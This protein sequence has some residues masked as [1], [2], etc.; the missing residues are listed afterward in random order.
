MNKIRSA[1]KIL[2][3]EWL[4]FARF[5][6]EI[7]TFILL[8]FVYIIVLGIIAIVVRLFRIVKSEK[9]SDS[10]VSYWKPKIDSGIDRHKFQ[11]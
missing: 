9:M 10:V 2:K 4:R 3:K 1:V 6:G 11:F 7:N 8:S 5:I